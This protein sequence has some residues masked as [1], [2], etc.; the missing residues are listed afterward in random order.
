MQNVLAAL[1]IW[2]M[3]IV[4]A[5]FIGVL[6]AVSNLR[7]EVKSIEKN[8]ESLRAHPLIPSSQLFLAA[9]TR[10]TR[11]W[12]KLFV[13]RSDKIAISS[14]LAASY[15]HEGD[16]I[17][18]DSGTTI[19]QVPHILRERLKSVRVYTNN[20]LAAISTLPPVEGFECFLLPGRIDP[21]YG[22]TYN[23]GDIEGPLKSIKA[24]TVILA[25]P[26]VSFDDGPMV[27]VEDYSNLHFKR[28]LVRMALE[29]P[30]NVTLLVA[31]DWTKLIEDHRSSEHARLNPVLVSEDWKTARA[32]ARFRIVTTPPPESL[33]TPEAMKA[34]EVIDMF[35]DNMK[36]NKGMVIDLVQCE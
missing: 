4:V 1:A 19:D 35:T 29:D 34:R 3:G 26:A 7:V 14:R 25:A 33:R 17:V 24:R 16:T 10:E 15:V 21:I 22:A 36:R 8:L 13:Q 31:V 30:V 9:L 18:V 2:L 6:N 20:L 32:T 23:I 27:D 28:E 12:G 11:F 5:V